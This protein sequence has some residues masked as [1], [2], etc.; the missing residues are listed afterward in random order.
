[1]AESKDL[2]SFK[3]GFESHH[4]YIWHVIKDNR[5]AGIIIESSETEAYRKSVEKYGPNIWLMRER[6]Y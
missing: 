6:P 5:T 1:M 4:S 3:C 2:K